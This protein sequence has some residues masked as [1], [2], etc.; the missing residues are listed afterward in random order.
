MARRYCTP[1]EAFAVLRRLSTSCHE[2]ICDVAARL[3]AVTQ[4][5][6]EAG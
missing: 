4:A 5:R 6:P 3:V 1:D 2:R